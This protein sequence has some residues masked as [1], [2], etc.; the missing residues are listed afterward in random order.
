MKNIE[1]VV[2]VEGWSSLREP[3][4]SYR[5]AVMR[6]SFYFRLIDALMHFMSFDAFKTVYADVYANVDVINSSYLT[7]NMTS[8]VHSSRFIGRKTLKKP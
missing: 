7:N 3:F 8:L 4:T 2:W 1:A 6:Q 5:S